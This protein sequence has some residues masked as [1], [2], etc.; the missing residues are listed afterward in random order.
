MREQ[1]ILSDVDLDILDFIRK[2]KYIKDICNYFNISYIKS[3]RHILRLNKLNC[4]TIQNLGNL[5]ILK[6][7]KKGE[8]ILKCLRLI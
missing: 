1:I 4:L 2:E 6:I 3:N 7:N 8:E 5:K